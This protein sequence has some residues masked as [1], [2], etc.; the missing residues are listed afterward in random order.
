MKRKIILFI[1]TVFILSGC[2]QNNGESDCVIHYEN[3]QGIQVMESLNKDDIGDHFYQKNY[4]MYSLFNDEEFTQDITADE[5]KKNSEIYAKI[6]YFED[7]VFINHREMN[8]IQVK[9]DFSDDNYI[10]YLTEEDD[11]YFGNTGTYLGELPILYNYANKFSLL[12]SEEIIK[13]DAGAQKGFILTSSNRLFS[14]E[15]DFRYD[16]EY[17]SSDDMIYSEEIRDDVFNF[18]ILDSFLIIL[19][20]DNQLLVMDVYD[21]SEGVRD[22]TTEINS[23]INGEVLSIYDTGFNGIH[24][25]T[26]LNEIYHTYYEM[27]EPH[28]NSQVLTKVNVNESYKDLYVEAL[29]GN[30]T[31]FVYNGNLHYISTN[32]VFDLQIADDNTSSA[33]II[34]L[35]EGNLVLTEEEFVYYDM[36]ATSYN[37]NDSLNLALNEDVIDFEVFY[38]NNVIKIL[39]ITSEGVAYV[40]EDVIDFEDIDFLEVNQ[41]LNLDVNKK[42][43]SISTS[44]DSY[45]LLT[46]SGE[47]IFNEFDESNQDMNI[48]VK[49]PSRVTV[50]KYQYSLVTDFDSLVASNYGTSHQLYKDVMYNESFILEN[51]TDTGLIALYLFVE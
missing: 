43:I 26:S 42:Y 13:F 28:N 22:F 14:I 36:A 50:V 5:C 4:L 37:I 12:D 33:K 9:T 23:V 40:S 34:P 38:Q 16:T 17:A 1:F 39:V 41:L 48:V 25:L 27:F 32:S 3:Q 11:F 15:E 19:T 31:S 29:N 45:S 10:A 44:G 7:D 24:I 30:R 51:E 18:I 21:L 6:T 49:K 46:E 35:E 2:S 47:S 8:N 20:T